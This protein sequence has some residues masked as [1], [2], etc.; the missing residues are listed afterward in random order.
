[1]GCSNDA[2]PF[3]HGIDG[4]DEDDSSPSDEVCERW[5]EDREDLS[6][7][8]WSGSVE[9]CDPGD[10][11]A[12]ARENALR[13]L[14]LYRFLADLP[15]VETD[16]ERD[17]KAQDCAL[18]MH[19]NASLS[20][21]PPQS[22][23]CWSADGA[24]AA[25]H[26]NIATAPGVMAVDLYMVDPGNATTL[27]H[28][29][30][31][32]SNGLGPV[33]LGS[34]TNSSCMW[35]LGGSGPGGHEWTAFPPPGEFPYEAVGSSW[36]SIDETGWS[37]QS[38]AIALSGAQVTITADGDQ[39]PVAVNALEPGYGS[40]HAISIIPQGWTTQP[41]TTY[42]VEVTGITSPISYEVDVVDCS[43]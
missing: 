6:E 41:D 39:L 9:S 20:H 21:N 14:N 15:E 25:G 27:G 18:I 28:R 5:N 36:T 22:W 26:S 2:P 37:V 1:M 8:T 35:V 12:D 42:H 40:A 13:V 32:L 4:D 23:A 16:D 33:G 10:I 29:R 34:T 38:D 30:W 11:S 24:E 7:G 19:A 3:S 31:I 17:A 43:E